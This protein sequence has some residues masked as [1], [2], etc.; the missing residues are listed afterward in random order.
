MQDVGEFL[1][2]LLDGDCGTYVLYLTVNVAQQGD[3]QHAI[4]GMHANLAIGPVIHGTPVEPVPVL[5]PAENFFYGLLSAVASDDGLSL[6][7]H[8]IGHQDGTTQSL[9]HQAMEGGGV[10]IELQIPTP[11]IERCQFIA[12]QLRQE[13]G[14]EPTSNF[15]A[16]RLFFQP[17]N[18]AFSDPAI[19]GAVIA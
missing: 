16:D 3:P 8:A 13:L 9:C 6:P 19:A 15:D 7:I 4:K 18:R 17:T 11:G 5:E 2:K 12:N 10:D 14:G 1:L